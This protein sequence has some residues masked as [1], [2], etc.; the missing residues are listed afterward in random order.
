MKKWIIYL[1]SA[2]IVAICGEETE[3][4]NLLYLLPHFSVLISVLILFP[5]HVSLHSLPKVVKRRVNAL[6]N[7]QVKCAHIEAKFYEEVHE[8]E[9]K[10]A[11]LY[12]P[13]FDKVCYLYTFYILLTLYFCRENM[14]HLIN[15]LSYIMC[16]AFS[17]S[18]CSFEWADLYCCTFSQNSRC[19]SHHPIG[20]INKVNAVSLVWKCKK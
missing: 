10:Y 6:K 5:V 7:L 16:D 4:K 12:Q 1:R 19:T 11:A 8:L 20:T 13:L 9:R 17:L 18:I 2:V 14:R 3:W 15:S